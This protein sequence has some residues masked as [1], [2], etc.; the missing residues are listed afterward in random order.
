MT[1]FGKW[2]QQENSQLVINYLIM[3][4][5]IG[6]LGMSLPFILLI[7]NSIANGG[8][9]FQSSISAYY[10]TSMRNVFVGILCAVGIFL[11]SY[12][13]H[14]KFDNILADI[15][16]LFAVITAFFPCLPDGT[17]PCPYKS[18]DMLHLISA[19][20]FF[21][22]LIIFSMFLFTKSDKKKKDRSGRKKRRNGLYRTCGIIMAISIAGIAIIDNWFRGL[23][24]YHPVF[25]LESIALL[26]F[27]ISWY[28]KG[29]TYS[30]I[31]TKRYNMVIS[32]SEIRNPLTTE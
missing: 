25:W 12:K 13:G 19:G 21:S 1:R 3:R 23:L 30:K 14:N 29:T 28:V 6:I 22:V 10:Y 18:Y 5:A 27:G 31:K 20:V 7:G 16:A 11:F 9:I 17:V 26:A 2:L 4:K 8:I 15:G 32:E 24:I